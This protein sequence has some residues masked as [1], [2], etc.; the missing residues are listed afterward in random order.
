MTAAPEPLRTLIAPGTPVAEFAARLAGAGHACY[1]VGGSVRD[2]LLGVAHTDIDIATDAHPHAVEQIVRGWADA[3]WAQGARFGTVGF[4]AN[5]A[6]VEVTT[7]RA[8]VYRPESRKPYVEYSDSIEIDLSRRDFTI[9]AMAVS[10]PGA[11]LVD[12][13]GGARDL[14]ARI[15]RTPLSPAIS[16]IDDPLRMLR[17]AR[18]VATYALTPVDE[19]VAS[20][21][22]YADRLDIVSAERI[23][24]ELTKLVLAADPVAGFTLLDRTGLRRRFLPEDVDTAHL[25]RARDRLAV[26]LAVLLSGAGREQ[27]NGRLRALRYPNDVIEGVTRVVA[28]IGDVGSTRRWNDAR[29]RRVALR[30]G[31]RYDELMA[32]LAALDPAS[33]FLARVG[34]LSAREDLRE[35]TVPVDGGDVMEHLGAGPSREVGEALAHLLEIRIERGPLDRDAALRELDAWA[36]AR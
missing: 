5:G 17:A 8:E 6:R 7:F 35:I 26:R 16:F 21:E 32:A 9:N 28:L 30:A 20:M 22:E 1:L 4:E 23:R 33:A 10:V 25:S 11:E 12:P 13:H 15:L 31:P 24:D 36:R 3:V 29:V 19:I 2:A 27:A 34:E 14:D 18:F